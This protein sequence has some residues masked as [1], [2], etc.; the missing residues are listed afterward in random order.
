LTFARGAS[1]ESAIDNLIAKE[2]TG[3][4]VTRTKTKEDSVVVSLLARDVSLKILEEHTIHASNFADDV[5]ALE[6][7]NF[8]KFIVEFTHGEDSI[9]LV[10][11]SLDEALHRLG[12]LLVAEY[13]LE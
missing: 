10:A 12:T 2:F 8:E 4:V 3:S 1:C 13:G 5:L 11:K 7:R 6:S 9:K